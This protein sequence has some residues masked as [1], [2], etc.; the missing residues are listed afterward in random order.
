MDNYPST[1][2]YCEEV[3]SKINSELNEGTYV[4]CCSDCTQDII[5]AINALPKPNGKIGLI[6]DCS[7]PEGSSVND[8][9]TLGYKCTFNGVKG[10]TDLMTPIVTWP[11]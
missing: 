5:S 3:E 7:Q 1:K 11:R 10:A 9:T 2:Q 8:Y 6:H 4:K